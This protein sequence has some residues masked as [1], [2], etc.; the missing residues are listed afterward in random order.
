MNNSPVGANISRLRSNLSG[1]F[2]KDAICGILLEEAAA[3]KDKRQT[4][5]R[6]GWAGCSIHQ[7]VVL[8]ARVSSLHLSGCWGRGSN[9]RD[10][11]FDESV[12]QQ[13]QTCPLTRL[14]SAPPLEVTTTDAVKREKK[15]ITK[16]PGRNILRPE[17]VISDRT[18]QGFMGDL[19]RVMKKKERTRRLALQK[20]SKDYRKMQ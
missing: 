9:G 7:Q 16:H 2:E 17:K 8:Q 14:P 19:L 20:L 6:P 11:A 5:R 4:P 18:C 12:C 13:K 1:V 3:N 10:P 15:K